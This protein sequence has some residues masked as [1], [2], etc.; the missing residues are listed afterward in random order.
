MK[1]NIK[2]KIFLE[3]QRKR[4]F[5]YELKRKRKKLI[6][7]RKNII[8]K[9][10]QKRARNFINNPNKSKK[11]I[12]TAPNTFSLIDDPLTVI[13]FFEKAKKILAKGMPVYFNLSEITAMGPE[14][15]TYVCALYNDSAFTNGTPFRGNAPNDKRLNEMFDKA[16]FYDFVKPDIPRSNYIK[17]S[18]SKLINR[19][20]REKVEPKL[21]ADVVTSAMKH[22]FD[23]EQ[24]IVKK[25]GNYIILIESMANTLNHANYGQNDEVFNWWLLAYKEPITKITKFCFLDLGVGVFESLGRKYRNNSLKDIFK[26]LVIPTDNK[27]TLSQ[28]FGGEKKTSSDLPGRGHGLKTIYQIVKHDKYIKNFTLLSNDI[29]AKIE[30]NT[31]DRIEKINTNFRGT[32]YYWELIPNYE[33]K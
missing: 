13:S 19:V 28:I 22:T 12:L 2:K 29:K 26:K 21:A 6:L 5:K 8:P 17:D 15:L 23:I 3:R 1:R 20:I 30:Y 16:G 4:R 25:Q 11:E 7:K 14:T 31:V 9:I 33:T 18:N 10:T 24:F 32:L 27:R